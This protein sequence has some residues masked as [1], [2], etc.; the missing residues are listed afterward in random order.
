MV[1]FSG[2]AAVKARSRSPSGM[3]TR[4]A[5]AKADPYGMTNKGTG[6]GKNR[7]KGNGKGD[8]EGA[9]RGD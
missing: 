9:S 3:T 2:L 5:K 4:K 1:G 8:G 7:G 6:N